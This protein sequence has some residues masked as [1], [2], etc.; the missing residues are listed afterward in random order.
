MAFRARK[1]FG[2][3]EKQAPSACFS[4]LPRLVGQISGA[5][6]PLCLRSANVFSHQT[7]Q[8]PCFSYI[9]SLF[10]DQ[11]FKKGGMQSH[12]WLSGPEKFSGRS[13]NMPLDFGFNVISR[14]SSKAKGKVWGARFR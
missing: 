12:S 13:R 7:S 8:S 14:A 5:K 11:L 1:V 3:F 9:K 10:K 6:F 4:K 2:T